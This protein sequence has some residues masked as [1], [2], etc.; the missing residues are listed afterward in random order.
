M[1]IYNKFTWNQILIL[2]VL[3]GTIV[4]NILPIPELAKGAIAI[5]AFLIIPYLFGHIILTALKK[6][7]NLSLSKTSYIFISFAAGFIFIPIIAFL[8][9]AFHLFNATIFSFLILIILLIYFV[10]SKKYD[11][12]AEIKEIRINRNI[13]MFLFTFLFAV[14]F[15]LYYEPFPFSFNHDAFWGH[16][17]ITYLLVDYTHFAFHGNYNPTMTLMVGILSTLFRV[18]IY[19]LFWYGNYTLLPFLALFALYILSVKIFNDKRIYYV[20]FLA[21]LFAGAHT[22]GSSI[23]FYLFKP[24][25]LIIIVF[26]FILYFIE[27]EFVPLYSKTKFKDL[28]IIVTT[29]LITSFI[30]FSYLYSWLFKI[31]NPVIGYQNVGVGIFLLF[32]VLFFLPIVLKRRFN[33]I[34]EN[35]KIIFLLTILMLLLF[36]VHISMAILIFPF[37]LIYLILKYVG[38]KN[39]II[40]RNLSIC[41]AIIFLIF[42]SLQY[43]DIYNFETNYKEN[44]FLDSPDSGNLWRTPD[45]SVKQETLMQE[46]WTYPVFMIILIGIMFGI[47]DAKYRKIFPSLIIIVF[48]LIFFYLFIRTLGQE[49]ELNFANPIISLIIAYA[50]IKISS[51]GNLFKNKFFKS[52]VIGACIILFVSSII[53]PI[54]TY[55]DRLEG[56]HTIP[57]II[58]TEEYNAG[59]WMQNHLTKNTFIV[60]DPLTNHAVASV[61]GLRYPNIYDSKWRKAHFWSIL[62]SNNS[63]EVYMGIKETVTWTNMT[64]YGISNISQ[65]PI[66]SSVIVINERTIKWIKSEKYKDGKYIPSSAST[67][68]TITEEDIQVFLD[69]RYFTLLYN[70][71]NK[72]Y[73]FRVNSK[74][75]QNT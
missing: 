34:N 3:I 46:Y 71:T 75:W 14:L 70:D 64:H 56:S 2:Y 43:Y 24:S 33:F 35:F 40:V 55:M 65:Y 21:L 59:K 27:K 57:S 22:T 52:F 36:M 44:T 53:Y 67:N 28:L 20:S 19:T 23:G 17:P 69:I 49:R 66:N 32:F 25:N 18:D 13:I 61:A 62:S 54:D 1:N 11:E 8:L 10:K 37:I 41:A 16:I 51:F 63:N 29:F 74:E 48:G 26:L 7:I 5:P 50:I 58:T 72:L 6:S 73:I 30:L 4:C 68:Y 12:T 60:S 39:F 45:F 38:E 9:H 31:L 15:I 47:F 42:F